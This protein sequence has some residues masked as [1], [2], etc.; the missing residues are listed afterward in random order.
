MA[1]LFVANTSNVKE[2]KNGRPMNVEITKEQVAAAGVDGLANCTIVTLGVAGAGEKDHVYKTTVLKASEVAEKVATGEAYVIVA[3]E[4]MVEEARRTDGHIG[5]FRLGAGV[6][7]AYQLQPHDRLEL[8]ADHPFVE[9]S[10]KVISTRKM[11]EPMYL[12]AEEDEVAA[13]EMKKIE[14]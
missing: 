3:P 5:K 9:A 10:D 13:I 11:A 6:Y 4:I 12:L 1:K 14:F 2:M 8:S 7:T